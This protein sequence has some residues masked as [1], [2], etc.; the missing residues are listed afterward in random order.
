[1]IEVFPIH[2]K[3]V[4]IIKVVKAIMHEQGHILILEYSDL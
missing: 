4:G 1:M 2:R 3:T